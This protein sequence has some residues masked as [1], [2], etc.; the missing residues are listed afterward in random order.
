MNIDELHAKHQEIVE[1]LYVDKTGGYDAA[2]TIL[3]VKDGGVIC[4][5]LAAVGGASPLDAAK[6]IV[7]ENTPDIVS[8]MSPVYRKN[9]DG[10]RTSEGV[11]LV[12]ESALDRRTTMYTLT[13]D[14]ITLSVDSDVENIE[15]RVNLL[16]Q[17]TQPTEH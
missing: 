9:P 15:F 3:M 12:T 17:P 7:G 13:R 11:M 16:Y 1:R 14:P 8:F 6:H 10:E 4:V 2:P 5:V